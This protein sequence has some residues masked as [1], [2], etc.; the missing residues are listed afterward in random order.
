MVSRAFFDLKIG[1]QTY[2]DLSV[3]IKQQVG[4]NFETSVLEISKPNG[5]DGPFNHQAFRDAVE[6]YYRKLVGSS[7]SGIRISGASNI[8]MRNNTFVQEI[9]VDFSVSK[10]G[11]AW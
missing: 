5:Y 9:H 11:H 8:Q 1:E 10:D 7:G 3:D 2:K 4:S 6:N